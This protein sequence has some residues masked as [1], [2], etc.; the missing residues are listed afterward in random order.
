MR[1]AE[2][3][4]AY[5]ALHCRRNG[6]KRIMLKEL[7]QYVHIP[8]QHRPEACL[9]AAALLVNAFI[10]AYT[11]LAGCVTA[12]LLGAAVL[13][14]LRGGARPVFYKTAFSLGVGALCFAYLF[15]VLYAVDRGTAFLGFVKFLPLALAA[16][17]C[18][19]FSARERALL[20]DAVPA[21][22]LLQMLFAAPAYLLPAFKEYFVTYGR[23][24][25]GFGYSNVYAL[26]A[27]CG[28]VIVLLSPMPVKLPLRVGAAVVLLAGLLLSGS[29]TVFLLAVPAM[30]FVLWREKRLRLPVGVSAAVVIAGAAVYGIVSG[31]IGNIA[32]FLNFSVSESSYIDR[33]LYYFDAI[34]VI[35]K[36]PFGLGY[37]GYMYLIP[38]V[39]TGLYSVTYVHN[40]YLQL[41]LDVGLLPAGLFFF[42]M[43]RNLFYKELPLLNKALIGMI[44]LH[45]L[46][47]FDLQFLSVLLLLPLLAAYP[48]RRLAKRKKRAGNGVRNALA[49]GAAVCI[50]LGLWL[51]AA[52]GLE[53][54]GRYAAAL[55][56]YPGLTL[57]RIALMR[58]L[59][60]E[61]EASPEA[62]SLAESIIQRNKYVAVAYDIAARA[63]VREKDF[64][65]AI[66]LKGEAIRSAPF[67]FS[68]YVDYFNVLTLA[69]DYAAAEGDEELLHACLKRVAGL[70]ERLGAQLDKRSA[71]GRRITDQPNFILP[72]ES[73][74]YIERVRQTLEEAQ[75][76][77]LP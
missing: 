75:A 39:Q 26:F 52:A 59:A 9:L 61:D 32:R 68:E 55:K 28:V 13:L 6:R 43:F 25:G 50:A 76:Q 17:L 45:V 48:E 36:H 18:M 58:Q 8:A 64:A 22:G 47:D 44:A 74:D 14:S 54:A 15:T 16:Y 73:K 35:F 41:L 11:E 23:F 5:A 38:S 70:P 31:N 4:A 1:Q 2:N 53:S 49:G 72:Q 19:Q 65:G 71:L 46:V 69:I 56:T 29:R 42:G 63:A 37:K 34:P 33:L 21:I 60:A 30:V 62:V 66:R 3:A 27:L 24:H 10:G 20:L 40:D 12:A 7:R 77:N 57:S 51:G 67:T